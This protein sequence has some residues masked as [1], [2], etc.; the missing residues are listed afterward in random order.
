MPLSIDTLG[1]QVVY[2][3]NLQERQTQQGGLIGRCLQPCGSFRHTIAHGQRITGAKRH[4]LS[5][6]NL[7]LGRMVFPAS[8]H[9]PLLEVRCFSVRR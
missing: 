8:C 6:T 5:K 3:L 4:C 2:V 1:R 9:F 7:D